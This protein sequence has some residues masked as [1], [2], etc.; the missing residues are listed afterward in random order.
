[1]SWLTKIQNNLVIQTGDG[2]TYTPQW[3]NASKGKE[4]NVSEFEF[5]EVSG[6][7][8]SRSR[9][10]GWRYAIEIYFQGE[11]HLD[12]AEA[13]SDSADDSRAWTVTHPLYGTLFVQPISLNFDNREQNISKVTGV[14]VATINQMGP[15]ITVSPSDAVYKF[16]LD[17]DD[18]CANT[19]ATNIPVPNTS[20]INRLTANV[21]SLYNQGS[22]AIKETFDADDYFNLFNEANAA[23]VTA[24]QL[25]LEAIRKV[26]AVI[27]APMFF[28]DRVKN[29]LIT[30]KS[31]FDLLTQTILGILGKNDKV[32]YE[33]NAAV[34]IGAMALTAV[35]TKSDDEVISEVS[36]TEYASRTD[37]E[38]VI[39]TLLETY[40]TFI[41]NLDSIQTENGGEPD[42]YIPNFDS[43]NA[44][45]D[46]INYTVSNLF[47]IAISAKQE[48]SIFLEEDSNWI[49]LTHR[50]YGL[51]AD[52]STIDNFMAI[53]KAGLNEVLGVKK[54]RKIIWYV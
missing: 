6:T 46:L 34:M 1:M 41:L 51:Q 20:V 8:V 4:Y 22:K 28:A 15:K 38:E 49:L 19:W 16:K 7:F 11:D 12:V 43:L 5:I 2:K 48:R 23:I 36:S 47:V 29:R 14:I 40:N 32:T 9:P 21:N 27:N 33:N 42:S 45:S 13:F 39:S 50:F 25:P 18:V 10:K 52:D 54:G 35:I 17:M 37:V 30:L 26:Q 44:L 31:Q 24:T 53:N 3:L